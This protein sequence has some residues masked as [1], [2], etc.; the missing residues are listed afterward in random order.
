MSILDFQDLTFKDLF[1]TKNLA[2]VGSKSM[3]SPSSEVG[4]LS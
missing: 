2:E 3:I 4:S 1:S